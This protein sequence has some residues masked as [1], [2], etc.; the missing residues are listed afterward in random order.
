M[1]NSI[2]VEN[3]IGER[4]LFIL[5]SSLLIVAVNASAFAMFFIEMFRG[6]SIGFVSTM[7]IS[8]PMLLAVLILLAVSW[9]L[10]GA[11]RKR[12][13]W[14]VLFSASAVMASLYLFY[15]CCP[16]ESIQYRPFPSAVSADTSTAFDVMR[17]NGIATTLVGAR[18]LACW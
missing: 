4:V 11:R 10:R 8:W 3:N 15:L 5:V 7:I 1:D 13:S 17:P 18:P 16:L 14:W 2:M 6:G 9:G 12:K